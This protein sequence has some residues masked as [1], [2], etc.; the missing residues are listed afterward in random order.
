MRSMKALTRRLDPSRTHNRWAAEGRSRRIAVSS[1]LSRLTETKVA[2]WLRPMSGLG[3]SA[4]HSTIR[5]KS[6]CIKRDR[7]ESPVVRS[8]MACAAACKS[9]KPEGG[10]AGHGPV[11]GQ[12]G[13]GGGGKRLQKRPV[14]EAFVEAPDLVAV[15]ADVRIQLVDGRAIRG[16]VSHRERKLGPVGRQSMGLRH[17]PHLQAM[18]DVA[19]KPI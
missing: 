1:A 7:R 12:A 15:P 8:S 10:E 5:G 9:T 3:V 2:S 16:S 17:L 6:C 11:S 18:L 14:V 4:N 19:K 13:R